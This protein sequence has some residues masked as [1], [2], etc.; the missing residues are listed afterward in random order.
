MNRLF[1]DIE[2]ANCCVVRAQRLRLAA[3]L[4]WLGNNTGCTPNFP[5]RRTAVVDYRAAAPTLMLTDAAVE[6]SGVVA[7]RT[8]SA[9]QRR[10]RHGKAATTVSAPG[11]VA[12]VA[13]APADEAGA[14][15]TVPEGTV[16]RSYWNYG[17]NSPTPS[18]AP[19]ATLCCN[20]DIH[21]SSQCCNV[22]CEWATIYLGTFVTLDECCVGYLV[23]SKQ[24]TC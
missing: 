9:R 5:T 21:F 4:V 20:Q 2:K 16:A 7:D 13:L 22:F 19:G 8:L 23:T 15:E 10:S 14:P 1:K 18:P 17:T 24:V 6:A 12:A 11:A 3:D